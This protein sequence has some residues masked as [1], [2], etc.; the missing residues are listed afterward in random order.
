MK[1]CAD[2]IYLD[3][4]AT[5][6]VDPRV[7]EF[8]LP[9]FTKDFGNPH[10]STHIYGTRAHEA[11]EQ[12]RD[13]VAKV[14]N[15]D[16]QEIIFTSGATEANNIAL[17]G[18]CRALKAKGKSEIISVVTEH[19]SVLETLKA[20]EKEGFKITLLPVQKNGIINLND[21][22]QALSSK[23]ALVSVMAANNEIGVLQPIKD[24][25]KLSHEYG[26]L[27]HTDAAQAF[28]KIPLDVK[29]DKIDLLSLS[30]HK[31]Y[32]PKG[33]GALFIRKNIIVNPISYGGGQE[34][35]I[36]PGT[37]P[38]PLCVGLGK[39]SQIAQKEL[40]SEPKRLLAL[41]NKL[42][43]LLQDNLSGVIV[44]GDLKD[45]LPGNLNLSFKGVDSK[46]LLSSFKGIAV[47]GGSACT[48]DN[49]EV[50]YVVRAIDPGND[51]PPATL[52]LSLGRFTSEEDIGKA[53]SEIISVVKELREKNPAGGERLCHP[54]IKS[55]N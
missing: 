10:S 35:G 24:I 3:Y 1:V 15:A 20:L 33:V 30:G 21:L 28:G 46:P 17:L 25:A 6:P 41:R 34:K 19:K 31:I 53:A 5:T 48:S 43:Q 11:V 44:N 52:R 2:P 54:Q 37:T 27:F 36:R 50:S 18:T 12:A 42:L 26:A 16:P 22:R 39:A 38:T 14:I 7:L 51:L 4:Q 49:V 47:S 8:M 9:Y 40:I 29:K 32:G 23:T 55:Q 13:K 45:R